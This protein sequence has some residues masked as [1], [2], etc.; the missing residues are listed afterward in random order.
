MSMVFEVGWSPSPSI[1]ST[2]RAVSPLDS[3]MSAVTLVLSS[4]SSIA[5]A[6][7]ATSPRRTPSPV[8]STPAPASSAL[9][10]C[11]P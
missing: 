11:L 6:V 10:R 7:D 3:S 8:M 9:H 1:S 4:P 2:N 5:S